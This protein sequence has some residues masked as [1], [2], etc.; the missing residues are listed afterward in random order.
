[1][2]W[3]IIYWAS[4]KYERITLRF[5]IPG[6]TKNRRDGAFDMAKGAVK[7]ADINCPSEMS[8]AIDRSSAKN[9]CFHANDV[10]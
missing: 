2:L 8:R 1:M 6:H 7:H 10:T 3:F 4:E 9:A 5:L